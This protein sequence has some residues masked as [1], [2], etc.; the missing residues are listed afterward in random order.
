MLVHV[1]GC[2]GQNGT[3]VGEGQAGDRGGILV[4]LAKSLLVLPVPDVDQ[5]VGA[6]RSKSVVLAMEGDR[7]DGVNL[8]DS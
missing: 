8:F 5:T 7:V 4:E 1:R 6:A 3:V 2:D